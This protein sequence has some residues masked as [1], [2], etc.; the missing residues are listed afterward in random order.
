M[1]HFK[2]TFLLNH[3]AYNHETSAVDADTS[4]QEDYIL[5]F[6]TFYNMYQF[7]IELPE[8]IL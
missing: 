3:S 8:S 2:F 1:G 6:E 4:S 5:K 7:L